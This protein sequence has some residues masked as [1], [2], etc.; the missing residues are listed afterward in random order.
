MCHRYSYRTAVPAVL[1]LLGWLLMMGCTPNGSNNGPSTGSR[2]GGDIT[3]GDSDDD[4]DPVDSEDA[5]DLLTLTECGSE[6]R[7]V[8]PA[9]D[10]AAY[11]EG[12]ERFL[13]SVDFADSN[14][15]DLTWL[16]PLRRIDGFLNLFRNGELVSLQGPV[17]LESIGELR[18][19]FSQQLSDLTGLEA[20]HSIDERLFIDSNEAL[21]SLS[22]LE[23]LKVTG[24]VLIRDNPELESLEG[25]SGL[26]RV[27]G[28]VTIY[29]NPN[30]TSD[31]IQNFLDQITV[32][33]DTSLSR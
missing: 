2:D 5:S 9:Y 33:G 25:L 10:P 27:R 26:R 7:I 21:T 23:G 3:D 14:A 13:G 32:E 24:E 1:F 18:V 15:E 6:G 30:L 29:G 8:S 11:F 17:A 20:L 22:G 16:S 19:R 31:E 4:T 12:C 28:D